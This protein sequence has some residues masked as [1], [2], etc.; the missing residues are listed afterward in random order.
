[1]L[2]PDPPRR[3]RMLTDSHA[4][5]CVAAAPLACAVP[6]TYA[7]DCSVAKKPTAGR[8]RG[9]RG[10]L[11]Q[12]HAVE[13]QPGHRGAAARGFVAFTAAPIRPRP[14]CTRPRGCCRRSGRVAPR[15]TA[16]APGARL[17]RGVLR[18]LRPALAQLAE[19]SL[20]MKRL[21]VRVRR[22]ALPTPRLAPTAACSRFPWPFDDDRD[23]LQRLELAL[24]VQAAL[25]LG[26]HHAEQEV[27]PGGLGEGAAVALERLELVAG[28]VVAVDQDAE[29]PEA[30][31]LGH[32]RRPRRPRSAD[33]ARA[34][35]P[36]RTRR[37]TSRRSP[38][39]ARA[40]PPARPGR[41]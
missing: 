34:A 12:L 1:M 38:C 17:A 33:R 26:Q 40:R 21:S 25:Q 5:L 31:V 10:L 8:C 11:R 18:R 20:V 29:R 3:T 19:T 16:T 37:R 24:V 4:L 23:A 41:A 22:R 15:T 27:A 9:N 2:R 30:E 36:A 13:A 6:A 28:R 7:F 35:A 32:P 14:S 39:A